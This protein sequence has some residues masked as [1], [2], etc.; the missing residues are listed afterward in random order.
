MQ[1][2]ERVGRIAAIDWLRGLVMVLMAL[3][4][5]RFFFS[6]LPFPPEDVEHTSM[7][8]FLT[9]W[10][11][12]FCAPLFFLLSGTSSYLS[13]LR[14]GTGEL[15]G[16]L[17]RRG[18]WLVVLELTVIGFAWS[19][20]PGSS[21]AGVIWCLGWSMILLALLVRLP[22]RV[23]GALALVV[24]A[25]HDLLDGVQSSNGLWHILHVAGPMQLGPVHY[26]VLFPIIPWACVMALGYAMGPLFTR[27][28]RE[29]RR[30]LAITGAAATLL[31]VALRLTNVY[32]N[33]AGSYQRGGPGHFHAYD[34]VS[35]TII[36]FLDTEKYPPSLQFLLMT[37]G[38][39][40]IALAALDALLE[41]RMFARW[42]I[43]F[44]RVPFA[45]YVAHLY[46][47]H[48]AAIAVSAITHRDSWPLEAVWI[49]WILIVALLYPFCRLVERLKEGRREWW[50]SYV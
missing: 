7:A 36:A 29:R 33:P 17:W 49:F 31:F 35:R 9:R 14:R 8:L 32:G 42:M 5:V 45:F 3:D 37:L 2:G 12:H 46:V 40:L 19:F 48:L 11:T 22:L 41:K 25:G 27:A 6:H 16:H 20:R 43:T 1:T 15:A 30:L 26:F 21:F 24:I 13:G 10:V 28:P 50:W 34:S 38:P 44:G 39:S 18:L 4:H 47:I 23:T